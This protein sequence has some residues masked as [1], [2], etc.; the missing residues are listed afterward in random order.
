MVM[1]S[2]GERAT[3]VHEVYGKTFLTFYLDDWRSRDDVLAAEYVCGGDLVEA[4]KRCS[5]VYGKEFEKK[6]VT[7][8]YTCMYTLLKNVCAKESQCSTV[9]SDQSVTWEATDSMS[10]SFLAA[11]L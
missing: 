9:S 5:C 6:C 8:T 2:P 4:C 10:A 3:L 11:S 1:Y 7:Y